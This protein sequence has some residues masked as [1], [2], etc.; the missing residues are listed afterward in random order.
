V[1][2]RRD[3]G[4]GAWET[5]E[6]GGAGVAAIWDWPA[7]S[8]GLWLA[9]TAATTLTLARGEIGGRAWTPVALP[10]LAEHGLQNAFFLHGLTP[11]SGSLPPPLPTAVFS[12][13]SGGQTQLWCA[14]FEVPDAVTAV[15]SASAPEQAHAGAPLGGASAPSAIALGPPFPNPFNGA[16]RVPYWT[17]AP[18]EAELAVYDLLGQRLAFLAQGGHAAGHHHA[19]WDG[20]DAAGRPLASGIYTARLAAGPAVQSQRLVLLR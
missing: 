17:A 7:G 12:S 1:V 11:A 2:H 6:A 8:G 14:Q 4:S 9:S 10:S 19:D 20:T 16:V 13:T 5:V 15:A 3:A 18:G